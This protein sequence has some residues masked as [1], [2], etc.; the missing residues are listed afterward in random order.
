MLTHMPALQRCPL[1]STITPDGLLALLDCLGAARHVYRKG[2][3]VFLAGNAVHMMGI[4]LA[5]CVQ[6][7]QEDYWGRRGIIDRCEPGDLFAESFCCAGAERLPVSVIATEPTTALFL[8]VARI[9]NVCTNACWFHHTLIRNMLR[10]LALKGVA[11]TQKLEDVTQRGTREKLLSYLSRQ[12]L[13][14]GGKEFEIPFN[15]QELADYLS[16]DRSALSGELSRMAGAG[17]LRYHRNR[18]EL[19]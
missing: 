9:I 3:F 17:L 6:V 18:F 15:R 2:E 11:L 5:G 10:T 14:A 13:A 12:A 8:D 16:V 1:F 7:V 4:V 19:L